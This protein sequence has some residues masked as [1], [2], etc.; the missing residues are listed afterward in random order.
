MKIIAQEHL[1]AKFL[2]IDVEKSPFFVSKLNIKT[3]PSLFV[4][5]NGKHIAQLAGF[6]GLAKNP[7]KPDEWH[8]GRLQEWIAETGAIKY[9]RPTEEV[10]EEMKRL[11][12]VARGNVY[13][14]RERSSGMVEDEY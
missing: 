5:D 12:I 1:E 11:G 10:M 6:D 4:F 3:L 8:T 14:D 13:S 7:K 9:E 2:R